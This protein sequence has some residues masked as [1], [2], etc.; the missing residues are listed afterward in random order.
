MAKEIKLPQLGQTMEEGTVV[1]CLV[2]V[3]D[4]VK[5]G[6]VIF[7]I[8]T[9]KA[10]L[11]MESPL[12]GFVKHVLAKV[13]QTLLVGA[14]ML[15]LG[16]KDEEVPQS[17]VDSLLGV[18]SAPS[19]PAPAATTAI[20][21]PAKAA[22]EPAKPAGKIMASPRA[23]KLAQE[24]GVDLTTLKGTGP[25]GKI[26]ELDIQKAAEAKPARPATAAAAAA[27]AAAAGEARLGTTIALNRLQRI[28]AERMLKSKQEIPCFYLTVRADVT[29]LVAK[30]A[31]L[32]AAGD[33]KVSFNDFIIKAVATGL[34]RF[35]IM[36]GQLA[37]SAIKLA[38]A[39]HIG[40]AISVPDGL[41]APLVKDVNNKGLKQIARD[42]QALIERT[43]AD[44]LDLSDLEGGCTTVSN[45][46][47]FGIESFIPIVVPGQCTILGI[48]KI[49]DT[50]V[51]DN[52][53]I[54]VRK[55][56]NMTLSVDHK[57]ANGAYAAQFLD[58]VRNLLEEPSGLTV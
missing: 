2:K 41:V 3:G 13:D 11:E 25:A 22:P 10:T 31:E 21:E 53:N 37:G 32:N 15:V 38:D 44:K 34:E 9:D 50:C 33:V 54:L 43:R 39:I 45:L 30:R 49:T 55:L 56:M 18:E 28:T 14:P 7:E 47:A 19:G 40:L 57:V 5:K 12:G 35:P 29:N 48:G 1:N 24:L 42:S 4:E 27:P 46:G 8:E 6:D 17:F 23:K 52:G 51:P 58:F 16:E 20:A 26:T 36:T